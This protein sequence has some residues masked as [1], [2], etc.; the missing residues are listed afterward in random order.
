MNYLDVILSLPLL[1]AIYKGYSKGFI[2]QLAT[3]LAIIAGIF[4]ATKLSGYLADW[5]I[6]KF[7]WQEKISH[8]TSFITIVLIILIIIHILAKWLEN[9]INTTSL[10]FINR[11]LGVIFSVIRMLFIISLLL[12]ILNNINKKIEFVRK[13]D[14]D[15]SFMYNKISNIAPTV[16]P[17]LNFDKLQSLKDH[18]KQSK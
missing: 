7:Q 12:F 15:E 14:V 13:K 10:G 17:Y 2:H 16:F 9:S 4:I 3:L 5:F 18:C 6:R 11:L 1:W 8:F